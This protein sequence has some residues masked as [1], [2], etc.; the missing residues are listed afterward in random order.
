M[1]GNTHFLF[2][3]DMQQ[4]TALILLFPFEINNRFALSFLFE[5]NTH[6]RAMDVGVV[7]G[8]PEA[9]LWAHVRMSHHVLFFL[10]V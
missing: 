5:L 9:G 1:Q 6:A 2:G 10:V 8:T 3:Q 7:A 4:H